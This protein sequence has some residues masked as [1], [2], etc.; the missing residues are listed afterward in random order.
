MQNTEQTIAKYAVDDN[1]FRL[2]ST[3]HKKNIQPLDIFWLGGGELP[4]KKLFT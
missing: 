4:A 2:G 3:N 1:L